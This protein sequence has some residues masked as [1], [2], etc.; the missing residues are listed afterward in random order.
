MASPSGSSAHSLSAGGPLLH[1]GL[2]GCALINMISAR[3][4]AFR[5]L[6]VPLDEGLRVGLGAESRAGEVDVLLDGQVAGKLKGDEVIQVSA[7]ECEYVFGG[8]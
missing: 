7:M 1:P 3:T 6:V 8:C 2:P 5:P 4:M